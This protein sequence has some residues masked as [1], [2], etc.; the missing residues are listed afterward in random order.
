[1]SKSYSQLLKDI[2]NGE[3]ISIILIPNRREVI[4][5]FT[6][7]EKKSIPIFYNDQKILR[8]SEQFDV[9]LTV[10]DLRSEQRLA[11]L[12]SGLGLVLIFIF[13][14][15]FL[16]RRS[17]KLINNMQSFSRRSSQVKQ[18]EI[19]TITFDDVAGLSEE[20]EEL[21]EIVTFLKN[22]Q[23]LIDLGAI[24]P[25]GVLLVGPPGTGKTLL[26]RAIA[27]E[28]NV[29]FF[30]ISASEFVEMFVGVGAG[31][32]RDLFK[33]ATAKSPCIVFI[34]E[35]DSIGRQRGAGIGGGND[36]REQ[37]LNQLLTEMD[38][39]ASNSG[40]IVIA[41]TNRPDILDRALTRP[42]R[43]DRRIDILLPDR[44]ARYKI[45]S[46][47]ARTK[48]L[49][50]SVN[51]MDWA[52]KTPG[53]SGADLQNL[54]NE[55]AIYAARKDKKNISSIELDRALEKTRFGLLSRPITDSTKKRQI[56]YQIIG[57][58]LVALLI[59]S[60]DKLEKISLFKSPGSLNGISYLTP[61][62]ET[63]D[64]GLLT[65]SYI[66]NKIVI[67]L[68]SRA[69]E[70]IIFGEKEVTQGSQRDLEDVYFW[71]N[72]MVTKFG[73]SELGPIAYDSQNDSI[74]LGRDFMQNKKEYSQKTSKQ[75]DK[76]II[77][78]A[79]KANNH[80]IKLLL[81]KVPLMDLLVNELID[82]ETLEGE[83]IIEKL[84][85]YL[86]SN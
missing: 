64:S 49:A 11:N 14:L 54:L 71:A 80:A 47:H 56:A 79:N 7:G 51:L 10:K 12:I 60:E 45:L 3:I 29:P 26:A 48:P 61:D 50:D 52:A 13:S 32:V 75:I 65:R 46:V 57:K 82:K 4:V 1:M 43:F 62:E 18:D 19:D 24:T 84:N 36:E 22:P 66:Y 83:Y 35:I 23:V 31:R 55:A 17:S 76:Q 85:S 69:A 72:Q 27:G 37:T 16:I 9:P 40:V 5:E 70:I 2:E 58:T 73:F 68:G 33:S 77:A 41:A 25:K 38:G 53:F 21:R 44:K 6:N 42:G 20:S 15:S 74:F 8:I 39:F 30:S 59:P 34:D 86:S 67:S 78:I 63:I 81:D 28:A